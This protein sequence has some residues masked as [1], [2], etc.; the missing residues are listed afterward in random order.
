MLRTRHVKDYIFQNKAKQELLYPL[1]P[2]EHVA[3]CS[4]G[5]FMQTR[6]HCC[7]KFTKTGANMRLQRYSIVMRPDLVVLSLMVQIRASFVFHELLS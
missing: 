7:V 5:R 4:M 2:R 3:V 1:L 6:V